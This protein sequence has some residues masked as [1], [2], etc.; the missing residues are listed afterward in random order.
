MTPAA[1][2]L[3]S[4][5]PLTTL[6]SPQT[7]RVSAINV[8]SAVSPAAAPY[9]PRTC[10]WVPGRRGTCSCWAASQRAPCRRRCSRLHTAHT[11]PQIDRMCA[12]A[13]Q[14]AAHVH[15]TVVDSV[16]HT[17]APHKQHTPGPHKQY[18]AVMAYQGRRYAR[19][20]AVS[21]TA[22]IPAQ[23]R[24]RTQLTATRQDMRYETPYPTSWQHVRPLQ[25]RLLLSS[26]SNQPCCCAGLNAATV[27][28]GVGDA[29]IQLC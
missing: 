23:D 21:C 2:L 20:Q 16:Q 4:R 15:R 13:H 12:E 19:L 9:A 10:A 1:A 6:L 29:G 28:V 27:A 25:L 5:R 3:F 7:P 14:Q 11:S 17:P 24:L 18:T 22:D 26:K 8:L